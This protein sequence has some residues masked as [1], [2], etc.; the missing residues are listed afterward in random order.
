MVHIPSIGAHFIIKRK[1]MATQSGTV[2]FEGTLGN[3][4][5]YRMNGKYYLKT[6]TSLT[7]RKILSSNCFSNT[8][9]N[10]KWF[11]EAQSI[12]KQ[13]YHELPPN[14]HNQ[15][16]VWYPLRNKAQALVRKELP[17]E[18]IIILLRTEFVSDRIPTRNQ[19]LVD[20]KTIHQQPRHRKEIAEEI[21]LGK[22]INSGVVLSLVD[23]LAAS[24]AF[25]QTVLAARAGA[26]NISLLPAKM[27]QLSKKFRR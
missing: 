11:G 8:R 10:A 26:N 23:Q 20:T 19:T 14:K 1:D 3:I 27:K 16:K 5:G 6:K 7:R 9:R 21:F 15:Y 2:L 17:R 13:V 12:A 25:V 4:T 24:R 18:Q 22:E